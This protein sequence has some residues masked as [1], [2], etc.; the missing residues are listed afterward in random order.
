MTDTIDAPWWLPEDAPIALDDGAPQPEEPRTAGAARFQC[1]ICGGPSTHEPSACERCGSERVLVGGSEP[2]AEAE[3]ESEPEPK[4]KAQRKRKPKPPP[5]AEPE[6]EPEPE[7]VV[8]ELAAEREARAASGAYRDPFPGKNLAAMTSAFASCGFAFRFNSR[9]LGIEYLADGRW[10]RLDDR[11]AA[12]AQETIGA[13]FFIKTERGPRP[14]HFGRERWSLCLDAYL[15]DRECDPFEDYLEMLPP[16]DGTGRLD[17]Y[18]V[19]LFGVQDGDLE[20]WV[21]RYLFLACVQ[22]TFEPACLL[23]EMPVLIG[24]QDIGKSALTRVVLP[25]DIPGLHSDGLRWDAQAAQQVDATR[26]R[27]IVEVSEMVGRSRAEIG[28][29]KAFISRVD[30]GSVRLP[31]RRN[32]DPLPRRYILIGTTNEASDLPNDPSGLSRFVA[33]QLNHGSDVEAY[34]DRHRTQLWAEAVARYR[35]GMR[36]NMPRDLMPE[37]AARAELHRSRDE[38]L[39]DAIALITLTEMSIGEIKIQ[40]GDGFRDFSAHRI[41]SG[42][43]NAGWLK[44]RTEVGG[45]RRHVWSPPPEMTN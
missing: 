6:P 29:I 24:G 19:D 3:P 36:A 12:S 40:L 45:K 16:W 42:L 1:V 22:R 39:E 18:L 13:R 25:Q 5:E 21:G 43:R 10:M 20:R 38:F 31:W 26:G 4:P 30:D 34:M 8:I 37:Q 33:I 17:T 14:L 28:N 15:R 35:E 41:A 9:S 27:V 2:E 44:R 11:Y 7:P 32:P 23:R